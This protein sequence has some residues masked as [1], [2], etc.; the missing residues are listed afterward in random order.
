VYKEGHGKCG[1]GALGEKMN[2]CE[3]IE[4]SSSPNNELHLASFLGAWS[5]HAP[6]LEHA[7]R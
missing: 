5:P 3:K 4:K 1:T 2:C 6:D 7:F